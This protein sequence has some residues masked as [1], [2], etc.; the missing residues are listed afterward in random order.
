MAQKLILRIC[1]LYPDLMDTYGD[2]GNII[3]LKKRCATRNIKV[4][5]VNK[6]L[7]DK[8]E[9]DK[10]IVGKRKYEIQSHR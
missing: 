2:I 3:A 9:K 8:I 10:F 4:E 5:I 6:S 1:Y 7:N